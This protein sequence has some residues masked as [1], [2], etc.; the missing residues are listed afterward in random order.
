MVEPCLTYNL[1]SR[2][3]EKKA[4]VFLLAKSLRFVVL[5]SATVK[6]GYTGFSVLKVSIFC[7][8]EIGE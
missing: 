8:M 3:I 7:L 1:G 5:L 2:D 4:Y 6:L